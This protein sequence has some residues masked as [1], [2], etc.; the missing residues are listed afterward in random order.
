[1]GRVDLF[2]SRR[3]NYSK[4]EYWVRDERTESGSPQQW[5]LYNQPAGWFYAKPVS[6]KNTQMNIVNG[7]WATDSNHVT[8]ESDEEINDISRGCIVKYAEE[9]WLVESVQMQVHW[10][11][12]EFS[13]HQDYKYTI[14]LVRG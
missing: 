14:S 7:V 5:I 9:L 6:V 2:H 4:C 1:M 11:E 13:K 3:T 8:L 12:S 10:K